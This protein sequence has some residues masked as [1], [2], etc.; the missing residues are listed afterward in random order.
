LYSG[1]KSIKNNYDV[2]VSSFDCRDLR[3]FYP[4][5]HR[6]FWDISNRPACVYTGDADLNK[7]QIKNVFASVWDL[8]GTIQIPHHGD[9]KSFDSNVLGDK[10]YFCPISV[11]NTNTYGHPSSI[12]LA[13][14]V[15]KRS[16][17]IL[18]TEDLSSG[19]IQVVEGC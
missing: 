1:P 16:I 17:P 7:T 8:V 13:Q 10:Y 11:G 3:H 5:H 9:L 15:G 4:Y 2:F 6:F 18:V 19:F 12:L 14:V